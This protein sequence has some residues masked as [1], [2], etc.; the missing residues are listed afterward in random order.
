M[1]GETGWSF[2]GE[3]AIHKRL[4]VAGG[5]GGGSADAASALLA[6]TR[7]LAEAGGPALTPDDLRRLALSLGAD[8]PFF[9]D[10]RPSLARGVGEQL[11]ALPLPPLPLVLAVCDEPLST[12]AVYRA[13]DR[14]VPGETAPGFAERSRPAEEAWRRLSADWIGGTTDAGEVIRRAA[15]LLQNDLE[16]PA[17]RLLDRLNTT[18][19][20]LRQAGALACQVSGSGPT[21]F[22]IWPTEAEAAAAASALR[23]AGLDAR[24]TVAGTAS[25]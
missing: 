19:S 3:V 18:L 24:A 12:A 20:R 11:E 5:V 6:A 13:F 9:L 10:P 8:V 4:P 16:V 2:S 25:S 23:S 7:L 21:T 15:G 1:E 14:L 17:C 22:G